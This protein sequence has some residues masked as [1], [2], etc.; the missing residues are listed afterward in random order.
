METFI[1][2]INH[3]S[4]LS[5]F[6]YLLVDKES[7]TIYG[8]KNLTDIKLKEE[9]IKRIKQ[10]KSL[11]YNYYISEQKL[12]LLVYN[13]ST[14]NAFL[15]LFIDNELA[16]FVSYNDRLFKISETIHLY[17]TKTK[18]LKQDLQRINQNIL[19]LKEMIIEKEL[20]QQIEQ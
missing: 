10:Q 9:D 16:N 12:L 20:S 3:L 5:L 8:E 7:D 1:N 2:F 15:V 17:Q 18:F 4:E 19:Y 14:L 13:I 6:S 11:I